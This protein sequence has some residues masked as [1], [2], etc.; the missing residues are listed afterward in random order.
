MPCPFVI[1]ALHRSFTLTLDLNKLAGIKGLVKAIFHLRVSFLSFTFRF[2]L[3]FN[4]FWVLSL[5]FVSC[6]LNWNNGRMSVFINNSISW[7]N[8]VKILAVNFP[9][10]MSLAYKLLLSDLLNLC[11]FLASIMISSYTFQTSDYRIIQ[12]ERLIASVAMMAPAN[13]YWNLNLILDIIRQC[14]FF[15]RLTLL[16]KEVIARSD[17]AFVHCKS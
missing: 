7:V 10:I 4:I 2:C 8:E 13:K 6:L 14:F 11:N 12:P 17:S 5:V 9:K 16:V 3:G 15:L 1:A